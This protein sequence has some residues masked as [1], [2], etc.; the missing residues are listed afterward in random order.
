MMKRSDECGLL[1]R[2]SSIFFVRKLVAQPLLAARGTLVNREEWIRAKKVAKQVSSG[3]MVDREP[4][5]TANRK[6]NNKRGLLLEVVNV[7][8]AG[9]KYVS[10]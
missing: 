5:E 3:W 7:V 8:V 2:V 1:V 4:D 10:G 9:L 6:D